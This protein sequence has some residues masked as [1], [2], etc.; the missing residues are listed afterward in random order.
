MECLVCES[1][2]NL[3]CL[4]VV[5]SS[6]SAMDRFLSSCDLY[7]KKSVKDKQCYEGQYCNDY[8]YFML[9][10]IGRKLPVPRAYTKMA[11]IN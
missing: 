9:C 4:G 3:L 8:K 6:V 2:E 5:G 11:E 1:R 7:Y 10:K